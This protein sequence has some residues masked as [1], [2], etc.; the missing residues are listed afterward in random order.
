MFT[1]A[2]V[3]TPSKSLEAGLTSANLGVPEYHKALAQHEAYIE[4]LIECGLEVYVLPPL[5]DFPDACFIEDVA[6]LTPH[7]AVVTRP[8]A[9]SR[10][11]EISGMD[12]I[13]GQYYIDIEQIQAPGTIEGGDILMVGSHFYIGISDRTNW[14]GAKEMIEI[15]AKYHMTGSTVPLEESLHLKTGIAYLE[16]NQLVACGEM[17][18]RSEFAGFRILPVPQEESYAANC[19]WVNGSVLVPADHPRTSAIIRE[20]GYPV[21][22]VDVSEFQKLDGGLSCLSLR[23]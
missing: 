11:G 15:L 1:K 10:L 21:L 17:L 2:L 16:D 19:I 18:S 13:L 6:L 20:S 22:E 23:F 3:R 5:E 9:A 4:A 14:M 12:Q 8:G 7:C